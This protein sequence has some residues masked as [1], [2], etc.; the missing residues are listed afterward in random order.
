MTRLNMIPEEQFA[1]DFRQL[2]REL[3]EIKQAQRIGRDIIRPQ[4]IECLDVNGN[5]TVY[6][7]VANTPDGFGGFLQQ[8]FVAT[9][10]A[11]HQEDVFAIP[12]YVIYY[13]TPGNLPALTSDVSGF[14]YLNFDPAKNSAK[15]IS[16][17]GYFGDNV[18]PFDHVTYLKVY[19]YAT[20]TGTLTVE[21]TA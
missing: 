21:G 10:E 17:S 4:I 11:D 3:E 20:D 14:S 7:L 13:N 19:F 16:Y 6:D 18:F 12:I 2:R 8:A 9:L 5:P 15:K 1:E